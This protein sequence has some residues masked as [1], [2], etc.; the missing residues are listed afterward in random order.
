MTKEEDLKNRLQKT[1]NDLRNLETYIRDFSTFLPLSV[2]VVNPIGI[3]IDI[4]RAFR[5]L[6]NYHP[7]EIV[8][9]DISKIFLET[10]K[11]R[12]LFDDARKEKILKNRELTLISKE[13]KEIPV[14]VFVSA[15]EDREQRIIGYFLALF[16]ITEARKFRGVLEE[17]VKERTKDLEE[18]KKAL[19]NML[20]DAEEARWKAEEERSRTLAII[21]NFTDGLLVFDKDG[22]LSLINPKAE[23]F[24]GVE[25]EENLIGNSMSALAKKPRLR[26]L[27]DLIGKEV[28]KVFRK[29]FQI[30]KELVTEVT[31]VPISR[32]GEFSGKLV[33]LH[34]ITREKMVERM[35]T[36]FVSISAH[37]LR[38]PLSA[39][40][41][42]L[43]MLLDG[44]LGKITAEQKEF[45]EK[46][47]QSNERMIKLINDLLN[48]TRIEEGRYLYKPSLASIE[49]IVQSVIGSLEEEVKRKKL[50]LEFKKPTKKLPQ[51]KIDI[52]KIGLAVQNLIE[53]AIRYTKPEGKI[54]VSLSGD[55]KEI[56]LEVKDTGVGIPKDQQKRIFNKF[57]RAANAIR[58]ETEGS[59]LGL[60]IVKNIVEAHGGKVWF[61]SEEGKGSTFSFTLPIKEEF[62]KP[63]RQL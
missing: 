44:D 3:I 21:S 5:G 12:T 25:S 29:E 10:N 8:G 32:E 40:K 18:T 52:E 55:K 50:K 59:G 6:T 9:R 42:T 4:N 27:A 48:V 11:V 46:T 62:G 13:N 54:T 38:T 37:Q 16:D 41:W 28:K 31:T 19:T 26:L 45:I 63:L 22:K 2:V 61:K 47:Y 35:K 56:K 14:S 53:N 15:R 36:E 17:E 57:F 49:N 33:I 24:F 7:I 30:S 23:D 60:F 43:K 20:E 34:D 58:L 51:I 1:R 39:I